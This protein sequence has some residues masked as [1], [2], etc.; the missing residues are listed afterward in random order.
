M[1]LQTSSCS[2]TGSYLQMQTAI[3]MLVWKWEALG[4]QPQTKNNRERMNA[5]SWR[6]NL[7]QQRVCQSTIQ[8]Q[9]LSPENININTFYGLSRSCVCVSIYNLYLCRYV[10]KH[11]YVCRVTKLFTGNTT[12][13]IQIPFHAN[14]FNLASLGLWLNCTAWPYTDFGNMFLSSGSISLSGSLCLH[15]W[16]ACS[17]SVTCLS[18][19]ISVKLPPVLSA[20]FLQWLPFPLSSH[21]SYSV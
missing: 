8:Y 19:T 10:H 11:I 20:L 14:R 4:P 7:S 5:E 6:N 17:L 13:S 1:W 18:I 16:L 2:S 15:L 9:M 12:Q 21:E 3:D